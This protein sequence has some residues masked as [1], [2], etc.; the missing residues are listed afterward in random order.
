MMELLE[1]QDPEKR[2]LIETSDRHRKELEKEV[3]AIT[4]K[5]EAAVKNALI[6]GG[7]LT[8]GYLLIRQISK[9]R[10]PEKVKK[11]KRKAKYAEDEEEDNDVEVAETSDSSV[12]GRMG[13]RILTEATFMLLEMAKEQIR[14]YLQSRKKEE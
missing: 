2:K 5:T 6:I 11:G 3:K 7:A 10:K 8:V 14:E 4:E 12:I 9:S 13:E 1:T